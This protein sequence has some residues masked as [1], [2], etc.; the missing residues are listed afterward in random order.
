MPSALEFDGDFIWVHDNA[1]FGNVAL[2][3]HDV[4]PYPNTLYTRWIVY[5]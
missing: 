5:D 1:N 2:D 3:R 4:G